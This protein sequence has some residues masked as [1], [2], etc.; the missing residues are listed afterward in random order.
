MKHLFFFSLFTAIATL[1]VH[2]QV[3]FENLTM[4]TTLHYWKGVPGVAGYTPFQC[5]PAHFLNRND[6]SSFGDYWSG[7]AYS[8]KQ[9]TTSLSYVNNDCAVMAGKGHGNS[10]N[11]G[12][13]YLSYQPELNCITFP[14]P[15]VHPLEMYVCNTTIAYRSMQNGDFSAKKFGGISGNDPDYF[16]L[17][18]RG[19]Y[20][21]TPSIAD[22]LHVYLADFRDSNNANDYIVKDWKKVDLSILGI[23]DS[24]SYNLVS[25]DTGTFGMNTPAYFCIDDLTLQPESAESVTQIVQPLLYPNPCIDKFFIHPVA[26]IPQDL[27][28]SD[29]H[30][31]PYRHQQVAAYEQPVISTADWLPGMYFIQYNGYTFSLLKSE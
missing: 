8:S 6:T 7:W 21:G 9:D 19:W 30:G 10:S 31:K 12:V 20:Q 25:S 2:A 18:I 11:Y 3:D 27:L 28:I 22:T 16:R 5:G 15:G 14:G 13:A 4:D 1:N 17:D 24:L 26:S 29:V 23:I